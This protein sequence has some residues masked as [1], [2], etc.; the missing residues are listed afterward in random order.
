MTSL[1]RHLPD[2]TWP[3]QAAQGAKTKGGEELRHAVALHLG[4]RSSE[5][6]HGSSSEDR[7]HFTSLG[8]PNDSD[9]RMRV[10]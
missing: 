8:R 6:F 4:E 7:R 3:G 10:A 1:V 5:G 2:R 9:T